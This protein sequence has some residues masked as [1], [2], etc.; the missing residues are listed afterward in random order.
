MTQKEKTKFRA[1]VKWKQ[2]K[3]NIQSKQH[4]IDPIT[5]KPLY[6]G[7]NLHH[8][9]LNSNHYTDISNEDNFVLLNKHTHETLHFLFNYYKDDE[10]I[11]DRFE[12]YLKKMK[13][14]NN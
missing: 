13:E 10:S 6:K 2:F 9:D 8:C 12:F 3:A 1:T 11:L 4:N 7:A 5:L 14:L